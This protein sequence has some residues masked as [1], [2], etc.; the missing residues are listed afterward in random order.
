[1][2]FPLGSLVRHVKTG[3]QYIIAATPNVMVIEK[4]MVP[5]Y[6]YR[7]KWAGSH[8]FVRPQTE[9]EDGR[10]EKVI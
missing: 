6:A 9:M 10:F 1:M 7:E 8:C 5:A 2:L 4:D 3:N